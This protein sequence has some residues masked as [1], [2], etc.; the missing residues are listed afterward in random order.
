MEESRKRSQGGENDEEAV[1]VKR[2][3]APAT[4]DETDRNS[5]ADCEDITALLS[6]DEEEAASELAKLLETTASYPKVRFVDNPHYAFPLI[7]QSSSSYVTINGNEESCG[8][9]FSE[10]ESSVMAGVDIVCRGLVN[11]FEVDRWFAAE[12][13]GAWLNDGEGALGEAEVEACAENFDQAEACA[14]G[15]DQVKEINSW[16]CYPI[17]D[18]MLARFIGEEL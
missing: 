6:I 11:G 5:D 2:A 17:D 14:E 8:S 4:S 9:S 12:D 18:E 7:F 15:F 1:T 3:R 13:G 10:M 16:D